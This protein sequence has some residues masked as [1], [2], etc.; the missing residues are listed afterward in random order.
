MSGHPYTTLFPVALGT[1]TVRGTLKTVP[2]DFIV[3]EQLSFALSGQGH[4]LYL[5]VQKTGANTE[6]VAR[7]L[8]QHF[9]VPARDIGYAGLKDRHAVTTQWFSVPIKQYVPEQVAKLVIEGVTCLQAVPHERKLRKGAVA[10]NSFAIT[11]REL[12]G[13]LDDLKRRLEHIRA[14][15]V[16]NYFD[17][18]RFG[19]NRQ[20]LVV[21]QALFEKTRRLPPPKRGMYLSAARAWLFNHILARR[22]AEQS[23]NRPLPGDVFWLNGTKRFFLAET[24]DAEIERRVR[25]GDIHPTGALWGEGQL[26]S[27]GEV[28]VLESAVAAQWSILRDGLVAFALEQDRR[29]LRVIPAALEYQIDAAKK[30]LQV[31]FRLPAGSYATTLL[32]ELVREPLI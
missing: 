32:G 4:H 1:P 8:A 6:W 12:A 10:H 27:T 18:Q 20:N 3:E 14:H 22:I 15:G 25:E 9:K 11:L 30:N 29:A 23:W 13:D 21:A 16:P 5:Q 17:A 2:E 19:H 31:T 7:Q 26:A 28:A 24:P